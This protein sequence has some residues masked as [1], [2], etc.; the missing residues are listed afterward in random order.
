M[1]V[2]VAGVLAL[3]QAPA[4]YRPSRDT[5]FAQSLNVFTMYV[6]R[7][8][9]TLGRPA[10]KFSVERWHW[11]GDGRLVLHRT[12]L[13]TERRAASDTLRLTPGGRVL[14]INGRPPASTPRGQYDWLPRLPEPVRALRPGVAWTDSIAIEQDTAPGRIVYAAT[15]RWRIT[16]TLDTLGVR[17]AVEAVAEGTMRY[18]DTWWSD[19]AAGRTWWLDVSGPFTDRFWFDPRAGRLLGREWSMHLVGMAGLPRDSLPGIDTLPAGLRSASIDRRTTAVRAAQLT[20]ALPGTDTLVR[21][22]NGVAVLLHVSA[23]TADTL[24]VALARADGMVGTVRAVL[25]PDGRP[26]RYEGLWTDSTPD[27]RRHQVRV[28]GDS[29]VTGGGRAR[30]AAPQ[31][32]WAVA[33]DG[34]DELL[35]PALRSMARTSTPHGLLIYRPYPDRWDSATVRLRPVS[36]GAVAVMHTEGE[37]VPTVL[38]FTD[39]GALLAVA[40]QTP[41]HVTEATPSTG[42]ARG[43]QLER[44]L[45]ELQRR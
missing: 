28:E 43:L 13:D 19:S 12:N 24:E 40:K 31:G 36:G 3:Q 18:R 33:D 15:R 42:S 30:R 2:L 4:Q 10:H 8:G 17:A 20:R 14:T 41:E 35:V 16:R 7:D 29:V 21:L 22:E 38:I 45:A 5:A 1:I 39:D 6:V 44:I 34:M 25:G 23:R 26:R 32:A 37:A 27:V 11:T 9:D